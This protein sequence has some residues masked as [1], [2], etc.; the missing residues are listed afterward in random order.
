[1]KRNVIPYKPGHM[2]FLEPKKVFEGCDFTRID[3]AAALPSSY[4]FTIINHN[5]PIAVVGIT[6]FMPRVAEIWSVTSE[7]VRECR[8]YF[9]K[10]CND[11]IDEHQKKLGLQR[12]Q[13]TVEVGYDEG[14][15]WALSLGFE[16]EGIMGKYD[17]VTGKSAFL[18][19]RT[20]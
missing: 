1:M 16:Q 4:A 7:R 15:D 6:E 12:I 19:A 8:L 2:D 11:M 17:P 14:R 20:F 5:L 3:E 13:M 10:T 18:F 9:H